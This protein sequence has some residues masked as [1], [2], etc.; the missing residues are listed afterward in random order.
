VK[1]VINVTI[2][3]SKGRLPIKKNKRGI[4]ENY[5]VI[6]NRKVDRV[7]YANTRVSKNDERTILLK[8]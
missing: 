8:R 4:S 2:K 6:K 5:Q 7:V 3:K 1:E